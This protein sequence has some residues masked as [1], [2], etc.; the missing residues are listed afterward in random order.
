MGLITLPPSCAD[1]LE[2]W[3][4]QPS[5]P[6]QDCNGIAKKDEY[7]TVFQKTACDARSEKCCNLQFPFPL[8][9]YDCSFCFQIYRCDI[10]DVWTESS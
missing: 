10:V 7:T 5:G 1:S 6:V 2:I 4:P 9:S 3:E 8:Y